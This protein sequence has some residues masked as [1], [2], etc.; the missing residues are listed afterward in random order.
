M[1]NCGLLLK[2]LESSGF[3]IAMSRYKEEDNSLELKFRGG[4]VGC[5]YLFLIMRS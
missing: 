3:T 2:F 5:I 1:I 4:G